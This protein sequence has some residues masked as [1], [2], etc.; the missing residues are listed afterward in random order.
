MQYVSNIFPDVRVPRRTVPKAL[1]SAL[2]PLDWLSNAVLGT[3]RQ[4]TRAMVA[5]L[6]GKDQ[7]ASS[8]K[9]RSELGW[10]PMPF[11]QSLRETLEWI[12]ATFMRG[13]CSEP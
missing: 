10:A 6:G 3:P 5:E 1:L 9:L 8:A 4:V 12:R 13:A 11:E 2:P 7:R